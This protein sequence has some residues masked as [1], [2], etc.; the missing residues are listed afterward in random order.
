[1]EGGAFLLL[2]LPY[3]VLAAILILG[4]IFARK[5]ESLGAIDL[6]EKTTIA[7]SW[8]TAM[9]GILFVLCLGCVAR[10][11][12][13][14]VMVI[15]ILAAVLLTDRQTIKHVDYS[16]LLTFVGFFI[17]IGNMGRIEGFRR[18]LEKIID[19][20]EILTA[21]ISSQVISNVP[22]ALLLSGFTDKWERLIIGTNIG[23]LGTLIASMA[24]LISYRFVAAA[25]PKEKKRYMVQFTVVNIA[26]LVVLL[27]VAVL[28]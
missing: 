20:H 2:M 18:L 7:G 21:A 22:A 11:L 24:S 5:K 16:L 3:T 4:M 17:F 27:G 19:G 1:M 12:P 6:Q 26:F 15:L 25:Y 28:F 14:W 10:I 8:K 13:V 23:G 9:Y